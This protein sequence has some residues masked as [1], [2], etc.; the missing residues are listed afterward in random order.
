MP[1]QGHGVPDCRVRLVAIVIGLEY[2]LAVSNA[3]GPVDVFK[4][5][6]GASIK[7]NA[8]TSRG[9]GESC[10]YTKNNLCIG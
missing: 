8:E 2:D 10:R 9:T 7:L 4:I 5:G 6:I 3:A 1:N